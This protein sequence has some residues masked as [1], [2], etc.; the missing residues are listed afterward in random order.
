VSSSARRPGG[1]TNAARMETAG[2]CR[3]QADLGSGRFGANSP[4]PRTS[5]TVRHDWVRTGRS[6]FLTPSER[7]PCGSR[8]SFSS[9][10]LLTEDETG[11]GP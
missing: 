6:G 11:G 3:A 7:L 8:S 9:N 10:S 1:I 4:G 5:V 2:S